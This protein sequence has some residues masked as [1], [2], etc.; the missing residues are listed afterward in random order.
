M[1]LKILTL[2]GLVQDIAPGFDPIPDPYP[3]LPL[4][5]FY[6][7][8]NSAYFQLEAST[9]EEAQAN[10]E[11]FGG[12]LVS[13]NS[14]EEQDF[15]VNTFA[16]IDD[17]DH[18]KWIGFDKIKRETGFGVMV[19]SLIMLTGLHLNLV[20]VGHIIQKG[21]ECCKSMEHN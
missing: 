19:Q 17:G 14:Q 5:E 10:A 12:N 13:I 9:W 6:I 1:N 21:M 8:D 16:S 20:M 2:A 3:L 11:R 7:F 4:E 18:G 15:I